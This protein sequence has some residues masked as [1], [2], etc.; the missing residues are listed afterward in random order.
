MLEGE[1]RAADEGLAKLIAE[2]GGTIGGLD[3]DV[4]GRLVEPLAHR[5]NVF[6]VAFAVTLAVVVEQ[7]GIGG[8]VDGSAGDGP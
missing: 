1:H 7:T 4:F 2:V 6:P 5:E 8:H 3:E